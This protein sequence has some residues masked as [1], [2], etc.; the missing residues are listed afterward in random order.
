MLYSLRTR[1]RDFALA[2]R[3]FFIFDN[4]QTAI[5][6][7]LLSLHSSADGKERS[8][9]EERAARGVGISLGFIGFD[10]SLGMRHLARTSVCD[11]T[12]TTIVNAIHAGNTA[13]IV[14]A[15]VLGIDARSLALAGTQRA[16]HTFLGVDYRAQEGETRHK[17]Q[18]GANRANRVAIGATATP[19]Q[20]ANHQQRSHSHS[21]RDAAFQPHVHRIEGVA[22]VVLGN[23]SQIVVHPCINRSKEVGGDTSECAIR[24]NQCSN[25]CEAHHYQH[26]KHSQKTVAQHTFLLCISKTHTRLLLAIM[27]PRNDVLHHTHRANHRAIYASKKQCQHQKEQHHAHIKRQHRRH[28]LQFFHP[29]Q[30]MAHSACEIKETKGDGNKK[31]RGKNDS[32]FS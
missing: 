4:R 26:H 17:A 24:C 20:E 25:R 5:D 27:Q 32:N 12:R 23:R 29:T 3:Y 16:A 19:R 8:Q 7:A 9:R 31:Y 10:I 13:R 30:V 18:H 28:K 22:I 1:R 6:L 21:Q 15:V 14:D 2:G 11:S